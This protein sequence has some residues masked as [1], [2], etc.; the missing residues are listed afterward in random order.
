[1]RR[2][3]SRSFDSE[4]DLSSASFAP[5]VDLFT[6]LVVAILRASNPQPNLSFAEDNFQLPISSQER[7]PQ[8]ATI[9]DIGQQAIYVNG[10]R[11]TSTKYWLKHNEMLI[12]DLYESLQLI[13]DKNAQ[14]RAHSNTPWSLVDKT[15]LTVQQ[16]GYSNI[17][18]IALSNLSF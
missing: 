16:A 6:I 10:Q 4:G 18:L 8:Q 7:A 9:I 15:L 5:M 13:A 14:V 1:M 2:L 17:E 11:I 12:S 3:F